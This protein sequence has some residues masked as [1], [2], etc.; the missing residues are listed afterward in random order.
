LLERKEGI[1]A[2]AA[3]ALVVYVLALS[4]LSPV[5]SATSTSRTLSNSGSVKGIGVGIYQYSNCTSSVTSFNWGTLDPG[6]TVNRTVYIR[7]EGNAPATLSKTQSNWSPS[8]ASS[9]ITLNWNYAGQTL[10]VNQVLQVKFT[11][12]VSSS[13]SGIT[14]FSFDI[15]ITAS[16]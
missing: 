16:G 11:L 9:Y 6:A 13:I 4:L 3:V 7:N 2:G 14:N 12:V 5:M 1:V 8:N 15:T 10:S